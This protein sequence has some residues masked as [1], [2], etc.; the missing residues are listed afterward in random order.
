MSLD[1]FERNDSFVAKSF[2]KG[3]F[4]YLEGAAQVNETHFFRDMIERHLLQKLAETYPSPRQKEEVPAWLYLASFITMRFHGQHAYSSLPVLLRYGGLVNALGAEA[5]FRTKHPQSG[6]VTLHCKGYNG[7]NTYDRETPCDQDA[8]RKFA[9]DT[10]A[11]ALFHWFETD[12]VRIFREH[13]AFDSDGYFIGDGSYLFVPN[14]PSYEGSE[15]LWFDEKTNKPVSTP[16]TKAEQAGKQKRRCY[17]L[18]SLLYVSSDRSSFF[19]LGVTVTPPSAHES[20]VFFAM[21]DRI[22]KAHPGLIRRVLLDRGFLSGDDLRYHKKTHGIDFTIPLKSNMQAYADAMQLLEEVQWK[23]YEQPLGPDET[24]KPKRPDVIE[25]REAARQKTLAKK[26][27]EK[28]ALQ[29][30]PPRKATSEVALLSGLTSWQAYDLPFQVVANRETD[31]KGEV[32][33]WFLLDTAPVADP[34]TPRNEYG[35]RTE[36]EERHKQLKCFWDLTNFHSRSFSSVSHQVVMVALTYSLIQLFL[37]RQTRNDLA[38]A[39]ALQRR[40]RATETF[41]VLYYQN[42]YAILT[43]LEHQDLVLKLKGDAH[44]KVRKKTAKLKAQYRRAM[45]RP[46]P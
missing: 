45:R 23:P 44:E 20:P 31:R 46:R 37:L 40:L 8:V 27:A 18:V 36:I 33:H 3:D 1:I 15:V 25:R 2:L 30:P 24:P 13:K 39:A 41:V 14:N 7:K 34:A 9:K 35:V 4:D 10:D 12:V 17:K 21:L 11:E 22:A 29:K 6:E 38:N 16:K 19:Y 28:M 26:R 43:P 32:R 5:G 42:Y